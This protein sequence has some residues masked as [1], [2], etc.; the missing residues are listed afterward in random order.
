MCN[1]SRTRIRSFIMEIL[2][3]FISGKHPKAAATKGVLTYK[4]LHA[5]CIKVTQ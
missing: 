5:L 2:K 3:I 4:D 1:F